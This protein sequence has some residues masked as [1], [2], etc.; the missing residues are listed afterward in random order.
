MERQTLNGIITVNSSLQE[1]ISK[2]QAILKQL[3]MAL[4]RVR[5]SRINQEPHRLINAMDH[6]AYLI[7]NNP[8]IQ[9]ILSLIQTEVQK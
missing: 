6:I 1:M 8:D 7:Y 2:G 3:K 5:R 4:S 9:E